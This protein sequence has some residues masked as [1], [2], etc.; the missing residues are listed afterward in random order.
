MPKLKESL[1]KVAKSQ[2]GTSFPTR[3]KIREAEDKLSEASEKLSEIRNEFNM[4]WG[5]NRGCDLDVALT[6]ALRRIEEAQTELQDLLR[7]RRLGLN[8]RHGRSWV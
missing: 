8:F 5:D 2:I 7:R 4:E 1:M 3:Q 6:Y